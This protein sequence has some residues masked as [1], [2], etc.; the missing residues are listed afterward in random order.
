MSSNIE[1]NGAWSSPLSKNRETYNYELASFGL[2]TYKNSNLFQ[3]LNILDQKL[4]KFWF[5]DYLLT[6]LFINQIY[7]HLTLKIFYQ[8]CSYHDKNLLKPYFKLSRP[9]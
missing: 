9:N 1:I 2:D 3:K 8:D 7:L 6:S 4:I 5:F